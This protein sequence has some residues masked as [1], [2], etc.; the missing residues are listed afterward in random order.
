MPTKPCG[1]V[2]AQVLEGRAGQH[3]A[4]RRALDEALLD[5]VGLDDLLDARRAAR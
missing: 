4:A 1:T 3:A 2:Y 5:Q